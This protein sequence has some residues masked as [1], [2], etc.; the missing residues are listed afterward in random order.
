MIHRFDPD[1]WLTPANRGGVGWPG[2]FPTTPCRHCGGEYFRW[3]G[4]WNLGFMCIECRMVW[5]VSD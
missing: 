1:T 2:Y 4:D 5:R 3:V